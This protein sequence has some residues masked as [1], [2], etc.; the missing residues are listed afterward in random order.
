MDG[1]VLLFGLALSVVTGLLFG[2]A[3][4]LQ[5]TRSNLTGYMKEGGR[6]ASAGGFRQRIRGAL[7][8]SE[9]ALAFVLLTSAGLLIRSFFQ[10]LQVDTGFDSTNVL[11][12]GLPISDK[13][14]PDPV[15][16]NAYLR[17]IAKASRRFLACVTS[18]LLP[19]SRCKGGVMGCLFRSPAAPWWI[20]PTAKPA[21]SKW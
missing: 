21:S 2:L 20:A 14:F 8:V 15:R 19:R 17:Q 11:T 1:R 10:I 12:A 4:A 6:G 18:R 9:V 13:R 3:P 16:L 7:V 5:A